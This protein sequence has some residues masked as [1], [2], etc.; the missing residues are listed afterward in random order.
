MT[1][2]KRQMHAPARWTLTP[3]IP[4]E[5]DIHE[6]V[7]D[8][9]ELL[10]PPAFGFCYPAGLVELSPQQAARYVRAGLKTGMPDFMIFYRKVY[11]L[12]LKRPGGRLSQTRIVK[13][14]AGALREIVGQEER[15]AQLCQTGAVGD[16]AVCYSVDD[17]L[18]QLQRWRIPMKPVAGRIAA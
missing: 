13:T 18:A 9:L 16:L 14:K 5:R 7:A 15:F 4:T 1:R 17:V 12:E 3:F 6:A 2:A 11:L 10:K 8:L